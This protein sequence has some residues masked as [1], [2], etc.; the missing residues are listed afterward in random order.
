MTKD[1]STGDDMITVYSSARDIRRP[2]QMLTGC[3]TKRRD[4]T[5]NILKTLNNYSNNESRNKLE[6]IQG[7]QR[8]NLRMNSFS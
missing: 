5:F 3:S 6:S 1:K 8:G 7:S 4:P 2:K